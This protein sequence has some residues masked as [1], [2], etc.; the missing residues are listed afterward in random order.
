M[1]EQVIILDVSFILQH[2]NDSII[3]KDTIKVLERQ[4]FNNKIIIIIFISLVLSKF[5]PSSLPKN[6]CSLYFTSQVGFKS[7]YNVL[8]FNLKDFWT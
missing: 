3:S 2:L 4:I 6:N 7:S 8:I 1:T 5:F